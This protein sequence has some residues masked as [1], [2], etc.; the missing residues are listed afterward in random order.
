MLSTWGPRSI[1]GGRGFLPGGFLGRGRAE[2]RPRALGR[3]SPRGRGCAGGFCPPPSHR[4]YWLYWLGWHGAASGDKNVAGGS[5]PLPGGPNPGKKFRPKSG[6]N[7]TFPAN[8]NPIWWRFG[9]FWPVLTQ[10]WH[11]LT[12]PANFDWNLGRFW[13]FLASFDPNL[14]IL[15][16]FR[17]ILTQIWGCFCP[18]WPFSTPKWRY[19]EFSNIFYPN[20]GTLSL[21][22]DI[23]VPS[24][25][26]NLGII[27]LF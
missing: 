12:F 6:D 19:F 8:F 23:S 22:T 3:A 17:P 2:Q 18:F 5:A 21:F 20:L 14:G 9:P 13:P 4:G 1:W 15:W 7:L 16:L 25:T 11:A 27:F 26:L 10:I 24:F